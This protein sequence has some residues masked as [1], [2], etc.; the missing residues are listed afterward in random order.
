[1]CLLASME[2]IL[3]V[4]CCLIPHQGGFVF[5][6][7]CAYFSNLSLSVCLSVCLSSLSVSLSLSVCL[8]V[9]PS[10]SVCLCPSVCLSLS[11]C[12]LAGFLR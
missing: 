7:V 6:L 10:L 3:V 2:Q 9:S 8:S 11:V 4:K 5:T 12:L 1:M